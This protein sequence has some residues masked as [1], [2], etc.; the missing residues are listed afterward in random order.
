MIGTTNV[1]GGGKCIGVI[2]VKYKDGTICT[3]TCVSG[4]KTRVLRSNNS[5]EYVFNIPF[6]S[7]C[8][9]SGYNF[10]NSA[11]QV[12]VNI[13]SGYG[14]IIDL[15][16]IIPSSYRSRYKE[17]EYLGFENRA[18]V[19]FPDITIENGHSWDFEIP[20]LRFTA[21]SS[22][23]LIWTEDLTEKTQAGPEDTYIF[24]QRSNQAEM[25]AT[26]HY[27][28]TDVSEDN[29][30]I[31][32][33]TDYDLLFHFSSGSGDTSLA[34]YCLL[35]MNDTIIATYSAER[36]ET[37]P[38][39]LF[40]GAAHHNNL[41]NGTVPTSR[42]SNIAVNRDS[43]KYTRLISCIDLNNENIPGYFDART[44]TFCQGYNGSNDSPTSVTSVLTA[45]KQI[46]Q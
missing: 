3:C 24:V 14:V 12:S 46:Y 6:E 13:Y 27:G 17:V 31:E 16:Y 44:N 39:K 40:I 37:Q 41:S 23:Y 8:T 35:T 10:M 21:S 33:D 19:Y 1:G 34:P 28:Y 20:N 18:N 11:C 43:Q 7:E 22:G 4:S 36:K 45:G 9:I 42:M 25:T 5:G 38:L 29:P 30:F 26:T 15:D 2:Y 32:I